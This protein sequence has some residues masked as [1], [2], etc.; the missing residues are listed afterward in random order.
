MIDCLIEIILGIFLR[1]RGRTDIY[2]TDGEA[3]KFCGAADGVPGS[4]RDH[5]EHLLHLLRWFHTELV[6]TCTTSPHYEQS[7]LASISYPRLG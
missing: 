3:I 6:T 5:P 1:L 4:A 2:L 7:Q